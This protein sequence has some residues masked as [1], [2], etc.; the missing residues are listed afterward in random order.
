MTV[1]SKWTDTINASMKDRHSVI[2]KEREAQKALDNCCVAMENISEQLATTDYT[3]TNACEHCGRRGLDPHEAG[4][5]LAYLSKV[6][7]DVTRLLEFAKGNADQRAEIKGVDELLKFLTHE[8]FKTVCAWIQER[9]TFE[10][11]K[12]LN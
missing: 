8:Q 10:Q 1:K 11:A 9:E 6:I 7:N 2:R 4:K 12:Q 3:N 5:T